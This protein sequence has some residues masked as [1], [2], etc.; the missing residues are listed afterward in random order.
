M[1]VLYTI[2]HK[3]HDFL[4][5]LSL[6]LNCP[7]PL[8]SIADDEME[9]EQQLPETIPE[10]RTEEVLVFELK[11]KCS[12]LPCPPEG[13]TVPEELYMNA[14]GGLVLEQHGVRGWSSTGLGAGAAQG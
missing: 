2:L 7:L 3:G 13:A 14:K 5:V 11:V 12:R 1:N 9:E 6:A 4:I 10:V 8:M